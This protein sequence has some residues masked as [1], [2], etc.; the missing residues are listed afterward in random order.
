MR[1]PDR[2]GL[3][4]LDDVG[5]GYPNEPSDEDVASAAGI[6]L[7]RVLRFDLNTL[8]GGPLP[9]VA[10]ALADYP[11]DRAVEYGD[12]GYGRLR[13]AL[14]RVTGGHPER[15]IPGAG[16]DELIRL[17]TTS[18][19]GP[20]DRVLIP[21]PTFGMFEVEARL[22]GASVVSVPR[23]DPGTRQPAGRLRAAAE[24]ARA[25]L[26]WLCSPNNPTGD[27]YSADEIRVVAQGL[28][29]VVVV[30]A[31]Y[32]E[33]AEA[34]LGVA[35]ESTG[36]LPLQEELPN[37]L[38]L[39]SLAKAYGL[40]G[41]RVGYL[42]VPASLAARF[43]LAR[44]PLS[45]G[46]PSEALAIAALSDVVAARTRHALL[47]NERARLAGALEAA[48][49]RVL[50]SLTNF[51]LARPP[52]GLAHVVAE[53]LAAEGLVVRG[54]PAGQLVEWLRITARAPEHNRLL[55]AALGLAGR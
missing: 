11:A 5:E 51:V 2:R 55:L 43:D 18:V 26:V 30:D 37:L 16:A 7:E 22:A 31:V 47:V 41:A 4:R 14:A 52:D 38:I 23:D 42:Q 1:G 40:A 36:L 24:E 39:R 50:P 6:G 9:A 10:A 45:I 8:G 35:S 33:F 53:R 44:L 27:A 54:Y 20:G 34:T 3:L 21:T 28:A 15:I 48:G 19:V 17:V 29:G 32:Q 25:R 46:G 12:P 49:W 13:A